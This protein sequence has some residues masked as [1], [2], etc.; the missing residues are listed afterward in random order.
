M[1]SMIMNGVAVA[2]LLSLGL[3]AARADEPVAA[4]AGNKL[5]WE[6]N[7][8]GVQVYA[9]EA[10]GSA[11]DWTFKG[12]EAS[13]Y[14]KDG[15]QVGTH[16]AGPTWKSGDGSSVAGEVAAK[17]DAP[18]ATAIAWLLLRAKSHEGHGAMADVT[19]VRRV[20]T[21]GGV[22]PKSG[23]DAAH[24]SEQARMHYSAVYQF[25]GATK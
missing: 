20:D 6:V 16:F 10:K 8:D 14:G 7:A 4:P 5:L 23:C 17:A 11:H 22:A 25:F 21:K 12:P 2:A 18:E 1:K 19:Y 13:L 9:C 15:R 3:T 24:V